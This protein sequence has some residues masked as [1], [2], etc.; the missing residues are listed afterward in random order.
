MKYLLFHEDYIYLNINQKIQA[1]DFYIKHSL[2]TK[3]NLETMK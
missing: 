2:K 3:K 1:K